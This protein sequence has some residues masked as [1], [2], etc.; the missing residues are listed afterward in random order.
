MT[1]QS[2]QELRDQ[3]EQIANAPLEERAAKLE[4]MEAAL[5]DLLDNPAPGQ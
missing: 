4:A 1:E 3:I 2:D 5:R